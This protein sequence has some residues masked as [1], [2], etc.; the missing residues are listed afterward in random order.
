MRLTISNGL[1]TAT[2]AALLGLGGLMATAP[3]AAAHY[4]T[5]RCDGDGDHCWRVRCDDDGDDCVRVRSYY[6]DRYRTY[7]RPR[8]RWVCEDD[9]DGCHWVYPRAYDHRAHFGIGIGWH[10]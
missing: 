1:K 10:D 9:G 7:D 6:G 8:A 5:T 4:T 3:G 2:L